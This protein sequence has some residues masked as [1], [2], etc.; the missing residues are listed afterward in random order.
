MTAEQVQAEVEP[1]IRK[2][3]KEAPHWFYP[4][5]R[6]RVRWVGVNDGILGKFATTLLVL[7]ASVVLLLLIGCGNVA[8]LLLARATTR[9]GEMAIRVSIGATRGRL[10]RQMLTE[11]LLL[12][13]I[14]G[15]FGILL[16]IAG[17][18]AVVALMPEY[19]IPHEAVIAMNWPVLWFAVAVTVLTGVVFGLVPALQVSGK[20]QVEALKGTG[21]GGG[22]GVK[23]RRLLDALVVFEVALSLILLTGAGLALKGLLVLQQKPLG[24]DPDH[25][26][27]LEAPIGEGNYLQYGARRNFFEAIVSAVQAVPGVQSAAI[28]ED[29]TPPWNG[30]QT[31]MMLDNRPVTEPV[32]GQFNIVSDGYFAV[33][34]Q[35]LLRGRLLTHDDILRVSPV[36]VV[37]Q[38]LAARYY[39]NTNPIGHHLRVD[40]LDQALPAA[41]LKAPNMTDTFE[42]IGVVGTA[43]NRGLDEAPVPAVFAPYSVLCSPGFFMLVRTQSDPMVMVN[44]VRRAIK[45]VN[46]QQP[47]IEV[48]PLAYWLQFA[49]AYPRFAAFL[50]GVFGTVALLLAGAGVFSVVSYAVAQRT[51]E[52]GIRMAM[53]ANAGD[54]LRLVLTSAGRVFAIG[55]FA[56][57]ILSVF[58]AHELSG[59]MQGMGNADV[60]LF[61]AVPLVLIA[62]TLAACV[63]PARAATLVQ[64]MDALR[65]E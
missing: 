19:S 21:R 25:V 44:D 32:V 47:L 49:T 58:A 61:V 51:R 23:H 11:S 7:F 18:K 38:D 46:A 48:H 42:I 28:S 3:Q 17:L 14:G 12:A 9:D 63:L 50:F 8:N 53:G 10:V 1:L 64:P 13:F 56:G 2:F 15:A 29:G 65:H 43:R 37:T 54:V 55:L 36:A 26:L 30:L 31:R 16:A 41:L 45:N 27:T 34:R 62:A 35:P 22:T 60:G 4:S 39:G 5:Q 33:V 24:Y 52:F 6:F 59:R 20:T 40:V 57:L